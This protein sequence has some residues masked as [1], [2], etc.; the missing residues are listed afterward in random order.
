MQHMHCL[1]RDMRRGAPVML[2]APGTCCALKGY[3]LRVEFHSYTVPLDASESTAHTPIEKN[4]MFFSR[5]TSRASL[6]SL[7]LSSR[8]PGGKLP[9]ITLPVS[10]ALPKKGM[11]S[12]LVL[13]LMMV[14]CWSNAHTVSLRG[15][16][17]QRHLK[18][19]AVLVF[20][21]VLFSTS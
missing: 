11:L 19:H 9:R 14:S 6:S 13:L 8:N 21:D 12:R 16:L 2:F 17:H 4:H 20:V 10:S 3:Y 1:H 18:G 5:Q 15:T 7:P